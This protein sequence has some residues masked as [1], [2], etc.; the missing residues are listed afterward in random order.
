M[1][2]AD[3]AGDTVCMSVRVDDRLRKLARKKASQRM[4]CYCGVPDDIKE[5]DE[6]C[7]LQC[8]CSWSVAEAIWDRYGTCDEKP[9][10]I[11][12]AE[13]FFLDAISTDPTD[14][15][16]RTAYATFLWK[17]VGDLKGAEDQYTRA[18]SL[19]EE[20]GDTQSLASAAYFFMDE[21]SVTSA[22]QFERS[23]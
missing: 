9:D 4:C 2:G 6:G 20:V 7:N 1:N 18:A 14:P 13:W 10:D 12:S 23:R 8:S 15:Q 3:E 16:L 11:Q 5:T 17:G 19:A 21:L 22:D